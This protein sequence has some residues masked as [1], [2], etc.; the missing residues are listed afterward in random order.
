[1]PFFFFR[2]FSD[3][4]RKRINI[5]AERSSSPTVEKYSRRCR[6]KDQQDSKE[7]RTASFSGLRRRYH[8][9]SQENTNIT[10][11]GRKKSP[12]NTYANVQYI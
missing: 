7:Q 10:D 8:Y 5:S 3:F 2:I 9:G 1:M 11:H 12:G 4:D 6:Q